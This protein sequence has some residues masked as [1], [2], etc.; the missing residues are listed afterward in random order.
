MRELLREALARFGRPLAVASDR[1]REGELRD[2]L[3][4]AGVPPAAL[5][6]RGQGYKD[7][8]EDVRLFRRAIAECKV[9]PVVSLLLRSAMA[10]A[11]TMSDPA[12]NEKLA[13]G[14]EGGRRQRARDDAVAAAILAV[15]EGVRRSR[16][17]RRAAPRI[18]VAG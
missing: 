6:F 13:K 11:R 7:G 9:V 2:G 10:E 16:T 1:W 18:A 4:G 12:G 17:V 5:S 14:S 15:S 8:G 3:A